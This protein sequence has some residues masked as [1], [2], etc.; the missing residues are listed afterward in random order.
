M[1]FLFQCP[2][3]SCFCFMKPKQGRPKVK[4]TTKEA[5]KE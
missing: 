2:C 3:C 5:K 4:E 1:K